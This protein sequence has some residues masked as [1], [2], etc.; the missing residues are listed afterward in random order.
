M[1]YLVKIT[2]GSVDANNYR[3][4]ELYLSNELGYV[5]A[6]LEAGAFRTLTDEEVKRMR[7]YDHLGGFEWY[8]PDHDMTV[9]VKR[10]SFCVATIDAI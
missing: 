10:G 7:E 1:R 4:E 3:V 5:N 6:F 9:E 8:E 2:S